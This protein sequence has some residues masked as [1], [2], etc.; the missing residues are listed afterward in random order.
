MHQDM[1]SKYGEEIKVI[2]HQVKDSR[3]KAEDARSV[4]L[5]QVSDTAVVQPLDSNL[6][7]LSYF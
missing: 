1:A 6:I 2:E 4:P 5:T 7:Y 3:A